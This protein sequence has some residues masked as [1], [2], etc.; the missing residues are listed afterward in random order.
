MRKTLAPKKKLASRRPKART[1]I[2]PTKLATAA[3]E[4]IRAVLEQSGRAAKLLGPLGRDELAARE[5]LFGSSLPPS[6][7]AAM[8]VAQAFGEPELVLDAAGI[9]EAQRALV[10]RFGDD[11]ETR[12]FPFARTDDAILAFDRGIRVR[13]FGS[14]P[15]PTRDGELQV[16]EIEG[17]VARPLSYSF[18]HWLD[19]VADAREESMASAASLPSRLKSLLDDLGFR[20]DSP[21]IGRL[22]TSDIAAIEELLGP[23]RT[24]AV[25]GDADRLF[26]STGKTE[27]VLNVDDFSVV[28][29]FRTGPLAFEA[30]D[31]FRWLRSFRNEN[32]YTEAPPPAQVRDNARDLRAAPREPPLV[33]RGVTELTALPAQQYT[34]RAASGESTTDFYLLGR[35]PSSTG[36]SPSVILHIVE[37]VVA[38]A[39][40]LDESLSDLYVAR[41]GAMWGLTATHAVRFTGG[42]AKSYP[43]VRGTPGRTFWY[44]I[45]GGG[46]GGDR[47]LVW[48]AGALLEFDGNGFV[49]FEPD[50]GLDLS[51]SVIALH[52]HKRGLSMLVCG[53]RMGAVASF[54]GADWQDIREDQV[55]EGILAD[56][57]LFRGVSY[58]LDRNGSVW[59]QERGV[60]P[61]PVV[62]DYRHP[63]F[64]TERGTQRATHSVRAFD[65][66]VLLASD[67]GVISVSG[68]EP[69]F[70]TVAGAHEPV[71]LVRVGSEDRVSFGRDM[72]E[73]GAGLLALC[74]PH[75]WTWQDG[76]FEV[77]DM[78]EW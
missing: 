69:V 8:E 22:E 71:R 51:E 62:W 13:R 73:E 42:R 43:L 60:A 47:V 34:F 46:A 70:H 74:G 61:R 11:G 58:V 44:G 21:L 64:L 77:L 52:T 38:S 20:F 48:G 6:Y 32:F 24:R 1:A 28:G 72:G 45:G 37:G 50:A 29:H 40:G 16:V 15:P 36:R 33:L 5:R 76:S 4:R 66:G 41:D 27:L 25:R 35:A 67:G 68:G 63:A 55:I 65:G 59:R 3:I 57:D 7:V 30:E 53:D 39:R 49:P 2:A 10:S 14:V 31:L 18:G 56:M 19:E 75:V 9:A 17:G 54:D 12:Y 23:E 26:D 78:R